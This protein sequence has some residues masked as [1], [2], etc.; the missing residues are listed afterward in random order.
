[1]EV[2]R[3]YW[4][5]LSPRRFSPGGRKDRVSSPVV[6]RLRVSAFR[7]TG[8]SSGGCRP[9]EGTRAD[10]TPA[11]S[12]A[13]H[14]GISRSVCGSSSVQR[15]FR[16]I[17]VRTPG[18]SADGTLIFSQVMGTRPDVRSRTPGGACHG[19]RR[20]RIG[21]RC[22]EQPSA[23]HPRYSPESSSSI[24]LTHR[25]PLR[26]LQYQCYS[27]FRSTVPRLTT[28]R[29]LSASPPWFVRGRFL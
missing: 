23:C 4:Y 19:S 10:V 16:V 27:R 29:S 12:V 3:E 11:G 7:C 28:V 9:A 26:L 21:R 14:P 17:F 6:T 13:D 1:L 5:S 15:L 20:P 18:V 24:A 22:C 8:Q 2:I 25:E